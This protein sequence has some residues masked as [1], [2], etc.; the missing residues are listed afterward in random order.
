MKLRISALLLFILCSTAQETEP[1]K[2]SESANLKSYPAGKLYEAKL[3]QAKLG[4]AMEDSF[5]EALDVSDALGFYF[6]G[7]ANGTDPVKAIAL[8]KQ[9]L[10][11][12]AKDSKQLRKRT[13]PKI[14]KKQKLKILQKFNF[15][16]H[17]ETLYGKID[18]IILEIYEYKVGKLK[19]YGIV[20]RPDNKAGQY[21][22]IVYCHGAASG[23][24]IYTI[25]SMAKI[26]KDGYL[27]VAPS[28]RGE[29]LFMDE[30]IGVPN[31]KSE[32]SIENLLGEPLDV[33]ASGYGALNL[34]NAQGKKFAVIGHSFGSGAGLLALTMSKDIICMISYDAWMT[35][36]FRFYWERLAG[37]YEGNDKIG[38]WG[39][40]EAFCEQSSKEQLEG[41]MD[42]S[43]VHHAER[44]TAPILMYTGGDKYYC[45]SAYRIS[46]KLFA[47]KLKAANKVFEYFV[48]PDAG[49]N[50]VLYPS[51][52]PAQKAYSMQKDW[53]K[54]YHPSRKAR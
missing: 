30:I 31:P 28:F 1:S 17:N 37:A 18:G 26:A 19:Q 49:H 43:V 35:N 4:Y 8:F 46:H 3:L 6:K 14:N 25:P 16:K 44:I 13:L 41:L 33:L 10:S 36:P 53:L 34:P 38:L 52:N 54:K 47:A 51:R 39:S 45:D 50:F 24:P 48:M 27:I 7:L 15:S 42:R 9:G 2:E 40:W 23:V 20:I 32:G 21:P 12:M 22:V 11:A 5:T 29:D